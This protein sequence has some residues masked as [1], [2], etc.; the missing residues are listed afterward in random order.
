MQRQLC[1]IPLMSKFDELCVATEEQHCYRCSQKPELPAMCLHCGVLLC[2]GPG[3]PALKGHV[4]PVG[5][6]KAGSCTEHARSCCAGVGAFL[7][8]YS[9]EIVLLRDAFASY[10]PSPFVDDH[11]ETDHGL[12]RGRPLVLS[13]SRYA[14]LR[15]LWL[16]HALAREISR[17]R[18]TSD[19]VIKT[20][21]M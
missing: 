16:K 8:L 13:G 6:S 17:S 20:G 12:R 15:D 5:S 14:A 4:S 10:Y 19:K 1:L 9:S 3:C 18:S 11:G 7:L 2:A 21:W